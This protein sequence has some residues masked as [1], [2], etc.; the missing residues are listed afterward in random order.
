MVCACVRDR[1]VKVR[2]VQG[3]REARPVYVGSQLPVGQ[4]LL[5]GALDT[6]PGPGTSRHPGSGGSLERERDSAR[7]L[8]RDAHS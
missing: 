3:G 2:V 7:A 8:T 4:L 5:N 6:W 1:Q